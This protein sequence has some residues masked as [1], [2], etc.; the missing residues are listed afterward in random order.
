MA[1]ALKGPDPVIPV[2]IHAPGEESPWAAGGASSWWLHHSLRALREDLR[3]R[4][5]ELILRS[6]AD[7]GAELLNIA[8]QTQAD[9]IVWNRRY[10]PAAITRDARIKSM[11]RGEKLHCESFNGALLREPWEINTK[12]G[13]PYQ[14]FTPFW[15]QCLSLA[16]PAPPLPAPTSL[17][18]PQRWPRSS[19]LEELNLLPRIAWAT[20][21]ESA[22]TP[23]SHQAHAL[24]QHFLRHALGG[25]PA[26]RDR[27]D[28][29]GTSRM[30]PY[31][32]FG[33]ISPREIWHALRAHAADNRI[34]GWRESRFLTEIGWREFAHHLLYHFPET[35]LQP[36]RAPFA[37]F[38]WR[39]DAAALR[40]WQRGQTG[41][42]IV[43]AGMRQLWK[44]GW[45]HNR[46][47]MIVASFLVKDLM[48][49]WQEG[50][51]W[52]WDTLVDADL[53]SNTLGWQW[54][55]G[56]G[57]DAAPFFRIFNPVSQG[58]KF[59]AA[60]DYVRKFIPELSALSSDWIHAPW[61]APPQLLQGAGIELGVS[62]PLPIVD[63]GAARKRALAALS[64]LKNQTDS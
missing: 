7:T 41:Y 23:G 32:H 35:P 26:A 10:E 27:P 61:N 54:S 62:Y 49:P 43:D 5:S 29:D 56:C 58:Q 33:Q 2:Y 25:Y 48:I 20:G 21:I 28:L 24:L 36:L 38:A 52:F 12:S 14:V 55:A 3:Q 13:G 42:P 34:A 57:A 17:P 18:A 45:M 22:W 59:D 11:L 46:V 9:R 40:A 44:T 53:A 60:G 63:H 1:F 16:D 47:R 64:A 31:L 8:S 39:N 6:C 4:G 15:R 30:S 37:R 51:R 19:S 50:A